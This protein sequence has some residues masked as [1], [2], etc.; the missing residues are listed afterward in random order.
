MNELWLRVALVAGA[1]VIAGVIAMITHRRAIEGVRVVRVTHLDPGVYFFSS[2][3]CSTCEQARA[4]LDSALGGSGYTEF[5][6]EQHPETFAEYGV[7]QVPAVMMVD[8]AR[9]GRI[10]FGQPELALGP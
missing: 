7:D 6:W 10:S 5:A 1:L 3:S 4:K 8:D 9:R 2:A